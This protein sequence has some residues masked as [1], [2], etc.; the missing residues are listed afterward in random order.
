MA[1]QGSAAWTWDSTTQHVVEGVQRCNA[2]GKRE[3]DI[4][5]SWNGR[6]GEEKTS[7]TE[8]SLARAAKSALPARPSAKTETDKRTMSP[9][10]C[11]LSSCSFS[12][13]LGASAAAPPAAAWCRSPSSSVSA[14]SLSR[15]PSPTRNPALI[16]SNVYCATAHSR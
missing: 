10:D 12:C 16:V 9:S 15:C 14:S 8:R 5:R 7:R 6:R 2:E 4:E 3:S 13:S 11:S 1:S